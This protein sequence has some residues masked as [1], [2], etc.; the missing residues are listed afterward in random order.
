MQRFKNSVLLAKQ[1]GYTAIDITDKMV[2]LT[3]VDDYYKNYGFTNIGKIIVYD[4]YA[5]NIEPSG[6]KIKREKSLMHVTIYKKAK[7]YPLQHVLKEDI[8]EIVLN[9]RN[10]YIPPWVFESIVASKLV[11]INP[12][13]DVDGESILANIHS[14]NVSISI[15][16]HYHSF[17]PLECRIFSLKYN[18][19]YD[20]IPTMPKD[21][22]DVTLEI[23]S[24]GRNIRY[25]AMKGTN[26]KNIEILSLNPDVK[27]NISPRLSNLSSL[28]V[29]RLNI[30]E[31]SKL[32]IVVD[33]V[34]FSQL[35]EFS[36]SSRDNI[37]L[38]KDNNVYIAAY[39]NHGSK[40]LD[41]KLGNMEIFDCRLA[42]D[43]Q[44]SLMSDARKMAFYIVIDYIPPELKE[45]NIFVDPLTVEEYHKR[46]Q[47][48]KRLLGMES[49]ERMPLIFPNND[50]F[51]ARY[52][53]YYDIYMYNGEN[54]YLGF[55]SN[56]RDRPPEMERAFV[57]NSRYKTRNRTLESYLL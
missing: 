10:I 53:V 55:C 9:C 18:T 2:M 37:F 46:L 33:I 52:D 41:M 42:N 45:Y 40:L 20:I 30:T 54:N 31:Y 25:P 39:N 29:L 24:E 27:G 19:E 56:F 48:Q 8:D 1:E 4:K 13:L 34:T 17:E 38:R 47:I 36:C 22:Y 5:T 50:D 49:I 35:R 16:Y 7:F 6:I 51:E 28:K 23:L 57:H 12:V 32:P 26:G 14:Y 3:N 15:K 43:E 44:Y 21:A 11:L